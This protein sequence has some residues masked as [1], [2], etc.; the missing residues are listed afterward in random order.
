MRSLFSKLLITNWLYLVILTSTAILTLY[1][2]DIVDTDLK[3]LLIL[4]FIIFSLYLSFHISYLAAKDI[5][6]DLKT[7]GEKTKLI[8]AGDFGSALI[9]TN[10]QEI[11]QLSKSINSMSGRLRL[12]F[13]DLNLEKEKFNLLLQNLKEGVFAISKD[14]KILFQNKS[15]P[16]ALIKEHSESLSIDVAVKNPKLLK[17]L[18]EHILSGLDGKI[19]IDVNQKFFSARIYKLVSGEDSFLFIGVI[20]DKTEDRERQILR[21]EFVQSASHELKTPITSIKGYAETLYDKLKLSETSTEKKFLAA[22]LRNTERMIRIVDDMLTI[23]KLESS[24]VHFQPEFFDLNQLVKDL[25][26]TIEGFMGRKKQTLVVSIAENFE[27]FGDILLMEHLLLNLI[28]N[29]STYSYENKEIELKADK[30]GQYI[31]ISVTDYGKG[32]P[33]DDL[34]RIFERFYRVDKNRS[35]DDGGTGLGLSIVKHI[36]KLHSGWVSV[37]SVEGEGSTF[38][39]NLPIVERKH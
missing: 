26:L 33:E 11:D 15:I 12:Q 38:T 27:I 39:L 29:A 24:N 36:A 32:I 20:L 17:F 30:N 34:D 37:S 35:R 28:Q 8:S 25:K 4:S 13:S 9:M 2:G 23:S 22:I 31:H 19:G 16:R 7:L 21:E 14:K 1:L 5:T 3:V 6:N 10:F 18:N